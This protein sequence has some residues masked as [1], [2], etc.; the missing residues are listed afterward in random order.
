MS[1]PGN[2]TFTL[3]SWVGTKAIGAQEVLNLVL[4]CGKD[5]GVALF[6][7]WLYDRLRGRRVKL[8][9]ERTEILIDEGEIRRVL[10]ERIEG[11]QK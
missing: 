7:S 6:A 5:L 3:S 10:T 8:Q 2:A 11:E 9:I 1:V 4:E